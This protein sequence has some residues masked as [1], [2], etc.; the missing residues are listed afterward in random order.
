MPARRDT[1]QALV[2]TIIVVA[3]LGVAVVAV[4]ELSGGVGRSAKRD[5]ARDTALSVAEAGVANAL[6]ILANAPRPLDPAAL[7]SSASP[8]VDSV[9]G[10]VVSWYGALSGDTWRITAR[11]S[12]PN[13]AADTTLHR[14]VEVDAR[15][16]STAMNPAWNYV[17]ANDS[18]CLTLAN[19]VVVM[20]PLYTRGSLCLQQSAKVTGSP[21]TALAYIQNTGSQGVG[22]GAPIGELHVGTGCRYGTSGPFVFQCTATEHVWVSGTQDQ[23]PADIEKPPLD[24]AYWYAN[25]KPGPTTNCT[26]GAFPG[27]F[28]NDATMNRSRADVNLFASNYDC[29]VT[30]GTTQVGR[31]AYTS[32]NPGSFVIDGTVF[33]DGNIDMNGSQKVLYSGRGTIYASGYVDLRGSQQ[34][35]GAWAAGCDFTNWQPD[36]SMLVLVS[37]STTDDPSFNTGQ[38]MMFQGGIYAAGNYAQGNSVKIEGPKIGEGLT[39]SGSSQATFPGYTYL[40]AGAPMAPPVVVTQGWNG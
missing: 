19:S 1:G 25:A 7:P 5:N 33:F 27:G 8:Q 21:V 30:V 34:I 18:G 6:S 23:T 2:L 29:T 10:N 14:I 37:G 15:V 13:P 39:I 24:L 31:V 28:D 17:Y 16:G 4:L 22:A 20:E 3:A 32:G 26:S 36:T 40:P 9:N 35:C 38:S 12:V 11:A